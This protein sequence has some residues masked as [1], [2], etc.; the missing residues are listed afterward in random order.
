[1]PHGER[2]KD[3]FIGL[4]VGAF[5]TAGTGWYFFVARK[6][7]RVTHAWDTVDAQ[8]AA[9][10]LGSDDIKA[11]LAHSGKVL[12]RSVREVGSAVASASA[13]AAITG[14]IKAKYAMDRELS[15]FGISVNTTDG[16]VTLAGN[17]KSA[18]QIG[19]AM[20]IALETDGVREVTSTLQV[21][22]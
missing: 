18:H 10:H 11:E 3:F 4:L 8:L 7:P 2:M 17:V 14:K 15:V 20:L 22:R 21:K 19:K 9:W 16:R 12:R 13:D 6:D 1:M 5:L